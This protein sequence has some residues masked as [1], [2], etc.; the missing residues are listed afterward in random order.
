MKYPQNILLL[1]ERLWLNKKKNVK[2]ILCFPPIVKKKSNANSLCVCKL[3][4][5]L[6]QT[7]LKLHWINNSR[8]EREKKE[9]KCL[10]GKRKKKQKK[11]KNLEFRRE[12]LKVLK[13]DIEMDL[14]MS[15]GHATRSSIHLN[16]Y[17]STDF[18]FFIHSIELINW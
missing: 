4:S 9:R 15:G 17:L 6:H 3:C 2:K 7:N 13:D 14:D 18:F 8:I 12:R 16:K 11:N 10:H 1:A 5:L